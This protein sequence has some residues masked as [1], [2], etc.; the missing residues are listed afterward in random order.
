MLPI[1]ILGLALGSVALALAA[2]AVLLHRIRTNESLQRIG[3]YGYAGEASMPASDVVALLPVLAAKL[4]AI[5]PFGSSEERRE[6]IRVLLLTAGAWNTKPATI[7]G[8][9]LVAA[10]AVGGA[11]TWLIARGFSGPWALLGGLYGARVG[12]QTP[13]FVLKSRARQRLERIELELPELIDLLVVTLEAGLGLNATLQR[14]AERMEGPLAD[15]L[16]LTLREQNLGLSLDKALANLLERCD[17]PAVRAFV[18]AVAQGEALGIS[19]G[20]IMRDLAG[21]LRTR[22]RQIVQ[23]KAQKAPIKILFPLAFLILPSIFVVVLFP[24]LY[25]IQQTL[26]GG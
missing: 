22:R 8:Y 2:R 24:G 25:N 26:G 11:L 19:L 13:I 7:V 14:A 12:W 18:R 1:L 3:A 6:E 5:I 17:A 16:R 15:E 21:D 20:Q 4:G 23:E 10:V 9:R